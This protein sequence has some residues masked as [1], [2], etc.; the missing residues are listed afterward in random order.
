MRTVTD[1]CFSPA[2]KAQ[3]Q[4]VAVLA[5]M[6]RGAVR[7]ARRVGLAIDITTAVGHGVL[8]LDC[9]LTLKQTGELSV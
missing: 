2:Q 6:L 9:R 8:P 3:L 1:E 5:E 7:D 4:N